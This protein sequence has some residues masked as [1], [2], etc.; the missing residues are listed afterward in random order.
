[1]FDSRIRITSGDTCF[2]MAV[3]VNGSHS[4]GPSPHVLKS[5]MAL[6]MPLLSTTPL[7]FFT[8]IQSQKLQ[9]RRKNK[10]ANQ[11]K[12]PSLYQNL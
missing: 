3:W 12:N 6:A 9:E 8:F 5:G 10:K 1:M 11:N 7:L 2:S 4:Y